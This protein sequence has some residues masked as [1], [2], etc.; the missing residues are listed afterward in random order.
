MSYPHLLLLLLSFTTA[1]TNAQTEKQYKNYKGKKP[2][3]IILLIGDGMGLSQISAT[4]FYS[5]KPSNF[6]RFQ[7]IGLLKTTADD[8][9]VTDSAASATAYATGEKTYNGAIGLKKDSVYVENIVELLSEKG[10]STGIVS[11][12]SVT[13][14]TPASFYAHVK[15]RHMYEDIATALVTSEIDFFAGGGLQFFNKRKDERNLLLELKL[16]GFDID[17]VALSPPT[18]IGKLGFLLADDGMPKMIEGRGDFLSHATQLALFNLSLKKK[19]FFL[20]VEGSQIDWGGHSNDADYLIAEQID[21]DNMVGLVLDYA[22]K[23]GETL[24]IVTADH[25][26]GG[27]TLAAEDGDYGTIVP[28]FATRNHSATMIPVFAKGPGASL[29]NGISE[30]TEIFNKMM[31][32]LK[33]K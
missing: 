18:K 10:M 29:F 19:G 9:L 20:L 8:K 11:T 31:W 33:M 28:S 21:F 4:Q 22:E 13:H 26:T 1:L 6:E 12:S 17:T 27:F 23:Q 5:D 25:E 15:S 2:K 3:N 32:L 24:V 16:N 14:A 7:T 30:N